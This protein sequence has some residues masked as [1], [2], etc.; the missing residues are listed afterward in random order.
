MSTTIG[1]VMAGG[2][3]TRLAE[4]GA[5]TPKPLQLVGGRT[6]LARAIEW[7]ERSFSLSRIVVVAYHRAERVEDAVRAL[8]NP[9]V[10]CVREES[11]LGTAGYVTKLAGTVPIDTRFA[12]VNADV[13]TTWTPPRVVGNWVAS[14]T[15][16]VD[17]PYG[18]LEVDENGNLERVREKWT[19]YEAAAGIYQLECRSIRIACPVA[20]PIEMPDLLTAI[21]EAGAGSKVAVHKLGRAYWRDIATPACLAR[22]RADAEAGRI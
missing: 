4:E 16:Q 13:L 20:L 11:K 14:V 12:V 21:A 9:L 18:S 6:L 19:A 10:G 3:G 5:V 17:V 15:R 7:L 22:A 8:R 1:V 2:Y